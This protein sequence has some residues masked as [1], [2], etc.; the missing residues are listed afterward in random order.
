MNKEQLINFIV[1][2]LIAYKHDFAKNA[3]ILTGPD[4]TPLE[5]RGSSRENLY[6][7]IIPRLDL[8]TTQE[9]ADNILIN[10]VRTQWVLYCRLTNY[11]RTNLILSCIYQLFKIIYFSLIWSP[12]SRLHMGNQLEL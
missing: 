9:E 10:Q 3:L 6:G 2:D 5:I 4:P 12:R 8:R 7:Q 11:F 1:A